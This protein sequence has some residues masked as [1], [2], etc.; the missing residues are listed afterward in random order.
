[1]MTLDKTCGRCHQA[2][3]P[4]YY[5]FREG[6]GTSAFCK[7]CHAAGK[8]LHGYG[9]YGNRYISPETTGT[10]LMKDIEQ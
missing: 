2:K 6:V 9:W 7:E 3:S 5:F 4:D 8:I 1:M 10:V